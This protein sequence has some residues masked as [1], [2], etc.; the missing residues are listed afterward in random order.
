[1]DQKLLIPFVWALFNGVFV[2]F[3]IQ[4]ADFSRRH[5]RLI[6]TWLTA[7]MWISGGLTGLVAGSCVLE[8]MGRST[9]LTAEICRVL[10]G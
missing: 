4:L 10:F 3:L 6:R 5:R 8:L 1:M 2:A 7:W 9:E